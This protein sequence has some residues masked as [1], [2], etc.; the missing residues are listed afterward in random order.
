MEWPKTVVYVAVLFAI[1]A[2]VYMGV[3]VAVDPEMTDARMTAVLGMVT[4]AVAAVAG[5]IGYEI[6]KNSNGGKE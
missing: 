1:C 5:L 6:G 3:K 4:P 2:L